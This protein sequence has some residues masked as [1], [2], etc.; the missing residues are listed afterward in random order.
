MYTSNIAFRLYLIRFKKK[1]RPEFTF[2][3]KKVH[4]IFKIQER[5]QVINKLPHIPSIT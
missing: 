5:Q 4:F 1:R 2:K 3:K